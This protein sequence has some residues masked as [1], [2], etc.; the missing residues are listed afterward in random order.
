MQ[1]VANGCAAKATAKPSPTN[2][3]SNSKSTTGTAATTIVAAGQGI[4]PESF[5]GGGQSIVPAQ[6]IINRPGAPWVL[7]DQRMAGNDRALK[8]H[9]KELYEQIVQYL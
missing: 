4:S 1:F 5:S 8:A 7:D 9:A 3:K 6:D 2:G